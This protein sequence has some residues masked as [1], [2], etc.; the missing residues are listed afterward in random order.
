MTL[1]ACTC[2]AD[3]RRGSVSHKRTCALVAAALGRMADPGRPAYP[4]QPGAPGVEQQAPAGLRS[5]HHVAKPTT[6]R[7]VTYRSKLEADVADALW[8]RAKGA[9]PGGALV[10]RQ[11]RF[12]LWT[13]WT[14]GAA[15]P[16]TWTPDFLYV[17]LLFLPD[18]E[19]PD[20]RDVL[21]NGL[22]EVHEAKTARGLESQDYAPRLAAFRA[23][24]PWVPVFV[25]RREGGRLVC[26]QLPTLGG[27]SR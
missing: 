9:G 17:R 10:L 15:K 20:V 24:C 25:W 23:G 11:P 21:P 2:G 13:S 22:V 16:P 3:K 12:D 18:Q 8:L 19:A 5:R 6:R 7:G 1:P 4:P 27:G 14:D 26:K